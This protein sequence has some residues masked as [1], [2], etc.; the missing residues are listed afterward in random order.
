VTAAESAAKVARLIRR[1]EAWRA[2]MAAAEAEAL[3]W[4]QEPL[5]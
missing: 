2:A 3:A 1:A 4:S 5:S